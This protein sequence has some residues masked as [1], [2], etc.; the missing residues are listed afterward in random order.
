M[1]RTDSMDGDYHHMIGLPSTEQVEY[2]M[3]GTYT[4]RGSYH[5]KEEA[6]HNYKYKPFTLPNKIH[7]GSDTE[8]RVSFPNRADGSGEI[9]EL[10]VENGEV[11]KVTVRVEYG[12]Y[13][14][15]A[16]VDLP[17]RTIITAWL[18]KPNDYPTP[19]GRKYRE[20]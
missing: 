12:K 2:P 5:A 17:Q 11:W 4:V 6:N 20:P 19:T 14:L 1:T 3:S 9:V 8:V 18:N 10:G 15:S 13:D 7:I 16:V